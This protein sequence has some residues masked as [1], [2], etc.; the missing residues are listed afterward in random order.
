MADPQHVDTAFVEET[1]EEPRMP[2][3]ESALDRQPQWQPRYPG[4]G[5]LAGK[6]AI[7]TGGDSGIGRATAVL[8]AREG[9]KVAIAYLEEHDDARITREA[10]EAEGAEVLLSAGDLGDPDHCRG[11]V[12]AVIGKWGRL[13]V[14]VNNAGEQHPDEDVTDITAEQL[15]RTFQTNIFSM[16]YLVQAARPHLQRGAAIVNCTSVTMY[17][18]APILLDYSATKGAITAFTRS[19]SENLV[20]D[21]IR[22][23]AVA[24]GPIWTPLNPCGGQP[25]EN[26]DDFGE[27][28]PMGRPGEPNEVAPAFL[29]LA[30]NDSSYMSG[31]VLHPNGGIVVNG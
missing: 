25:P 2:G 14:L 6:V 28:T 3:H 15:Q 4:S 13:D 19:L 17:K 31:Q 10:C 9:A 23:N 24:P 8:F 21:G 29:F 30:C 16:F 12:D 7:V 11:L 22:V 20:A 5:R 27:D 1:S 26:M 18:G